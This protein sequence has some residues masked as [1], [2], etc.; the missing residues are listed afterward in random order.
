ML[1]TDVKIPSGIKTAVHPILSSSNGCVIWQQGQWKIMW[2]HCSSTFPHR[3][4]DFE[5]IF[6]D[7]VARLKTIKERIGCTHSCFN[8]RRYIFSLLCL[9]SFK[10]WLLKIQHI[11]FGDH[12]SRV[13]IH[14]DIE[15]FRT[16]FRM[17]I[18]KWKYFPKLSH[19]YLWHR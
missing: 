14:F 16:F 11:W 19:L 4:S 2:N 5:K 12:G 10:L 6:I 1:D 9:S 8:P 18:P 17:K 7:L 3:D 13:K 15:W